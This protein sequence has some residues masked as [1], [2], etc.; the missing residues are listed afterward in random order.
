MLCSV[1]V[2]RVLFRG[3][4]DV[5]SNLVLVL[6]SFRLQISTARRND[7]LLGLNEMSNLVLTP[8]FEL[9]SKQYGDVNNAKSTLQGMNAYLASNGR[10]TAQMTPEERAQYQQQLDRR[11][12]AGCLVADALGT[13]EKF[14]Q[15]MPLDW[16][17]N[18]KN[19]NDFV[20]ALL[21]LLQEDVANIQVLAVA[22]L[23]QLSMRKLE[24]DQWF[25]LI[26]T[27]PSALFEASNANAQRANERGVAP[28]SIEMLVEQL[29]FHRNISKM[30]STLIS[31]HLA[32]LQLTNI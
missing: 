4:I 20:A 27:L 21:H 15:S 8:L 30:G 1:S 17:F 22:C 19:G 10:T 23:Q 14:C 13:L 31:A 24:Q 6:H 29:E 16:I 7:I 25:R 3:M 32:T 9:L 28:H 26:S 12:A 5:Q 2:Q 11:D 18:V